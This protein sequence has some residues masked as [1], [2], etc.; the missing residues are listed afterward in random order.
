MRDVN[1]LPS[2]WSDVIVGKGLAMGAQ[3]CSAFPLQLPVRLYIF[4]MES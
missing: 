3:D 1:L 2:V 4:K